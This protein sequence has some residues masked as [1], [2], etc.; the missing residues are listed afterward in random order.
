MP[1]FDGTGPQG[2][3][4]MTGRGRGL[5]RQL[6]DGVKSM[7]G[8]GLGQGGR[9]RGGGRGRCFG[10]RGQQFNPGRPVGPQKPEG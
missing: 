2:E 8:S 9:P 5:C 6:V 10:G 7:V 3:G 4:K 1:R